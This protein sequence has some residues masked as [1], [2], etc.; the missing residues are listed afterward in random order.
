[1]VDLKPHSAEWPRSF[2]EQVP[3]IRAA[4]GDNLVQIHHIGS[5]SIPNILAKPI[6]DILVEVKAID[7]VD[8]HAEAMERAGF[9]A[10]G[11]YGIP[12]RRYFRKSDAE[13]QRTHHIHIFETGAEPAVR[14]IAFRDYLRAFPEK[15]RSYSELKA[16]LADLEGQDYQAAKSAFVE[17]LQE[18][19]IRW[20]EN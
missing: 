18:Q 7:V 5:T 10:K 2:D 20:M 3:F 4:L 12:Q 1:M 8:S 16:R 14:H 15:A 19:A 13:G 6:V 9:E 17:E 11:E